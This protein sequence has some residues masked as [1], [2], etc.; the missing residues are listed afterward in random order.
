MHLPL[1]VGIKGVYQDHAPLPPFEAGSHVAQA[2]FQMPPLE[3]PRDLPF[4]K[5]SFLCLHTHPLIQQTA[6]TQ[7]PSTVPGLERTEMKISSQRG[8]LVTKPNSHVY[9]CCTLTDW[10][11]LSR[12]STQEGGSRSA[13][14]LREAVLE[15]VL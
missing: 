8:L 4:L 15:T 11:D 7:E 12:V 3:C 9:L 1:M 13:A 6:E 2:G 14:W 5:W 10:D